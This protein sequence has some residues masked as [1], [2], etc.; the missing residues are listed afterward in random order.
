MA[1][2]EDVH[3]HEIRSARAVQRRNSSAAE[4]P[5]KP[6]ILTLPVLKTGGRPVRG[7]VLRRATV[8]PGGRD[9]YPAKQLESGHAR[10]RELES[11]TAQVQQ[12]LLRVSGAIIALEELLNPAEGNGGE[13]LAAEVGME[14]PRE[15]ARKTT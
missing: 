9:G 13:S 15:P 4:A 3:R 11:E 12:T 6:R 1:F 10:L 14:Q 7:K 2:P 8:G 5:S